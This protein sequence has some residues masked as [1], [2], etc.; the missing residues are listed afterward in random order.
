[1]D[2]SNDLIDVMPLAGRL[3]NK[4]KSKSSMKLKKSISSVSKGLL[5]RKLS[6]RSSLGAGSLDFSDTSNNSNATGK[7]K[8]K[9]DKDDFLQH[10]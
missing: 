6:M 3:D 8:K 1:M 4:L 2:F 9:F 5:L 7:L 10:H